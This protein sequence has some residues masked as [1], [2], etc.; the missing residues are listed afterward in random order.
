MAL[1]FLHAESAFGR[2]IATAPV[3]SQVAGLYNA[4]QKINNTPA[5]QRRMKAHE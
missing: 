1:S 2:P 5:S 3:F 4:A